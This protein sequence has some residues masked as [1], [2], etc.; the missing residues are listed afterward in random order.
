M[1]LYSAHNEEVGLD[2]SVGIAT[3]Y[4][5]DGPGIERTRPDV[6]WGP[7]SL[8]YNGRWV[9]FPGV[10]RQGHGVNHPPPSSVEVK[11]RVELYS[12]LPLTLNGLF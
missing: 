3:R 9:S 5:L 6:P 7:P 12:T 8:Q 10:K 4:A 1:C 2:C 11:E